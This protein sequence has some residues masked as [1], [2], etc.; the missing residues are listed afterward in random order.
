M[1][2]QSSQRGTDGSPL[3]RSYGLHVTEGPGIPHD[4]AAGNTQELNHD[5]VVESWGGVLKGPVNRSVHRRTE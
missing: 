1:E 4:D 5:V 2:P 3:P